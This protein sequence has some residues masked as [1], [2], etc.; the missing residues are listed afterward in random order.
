MHRSKNIFN[1]T[2]MTGEIYYTALAMFSTIITRALS[3]FAGFPLSF[4]DE[5]GF[6]SVEFFSQ[7]LLRIAWR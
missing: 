1:S 5:L 6:N 3:K 4:R 2:Q 7:L